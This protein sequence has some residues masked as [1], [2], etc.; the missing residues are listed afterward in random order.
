MPRRLAVVAGIKAKI[1]QSREDLAGGRQDH[2]VSDAST[3]VQSIRRGRVAGDGDRGDPHRHRRSR[4][5]GLGALD[6][7]RRDLDPPRAFYPPSIALALLGPDDQRDDLRRPGAGGRH[8]GGRCHGDDREHRFA[9]GTGPGAGAGDHRRGQ[10]DR[11]SDLRLDT[12]YLHRLAAAVYL[13][14]GRRLLFLPL[15]RRSCSR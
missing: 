12:V 2:G 5:P 6:T 10:S 14:G 3:F 1:P 7:H 11:R 13:S 8:S 4:V 9:S 15:A